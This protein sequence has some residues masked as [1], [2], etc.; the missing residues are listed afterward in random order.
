MPR[1]PEFIKA[2]EHHRAFFVRRCQSLSQQPSEALLL[3]WIHHD[4]MLEGRRFHTAEIAQALREQDD[5]LP[6]Y[7]HPLM[8]SIRRYRDAILFVWKK[9][10]N[11]PSEV[12]LDNLKR[13]HR[14]LTPLERDRPGQ[15]RVS[16]PVH[17]DYFQSICPHTVI[18]QQLRKIFES[19]AT[20][21]DEAWDPTHFAAKIHHRLMHA[22]PFRRNPGTTLRLFTN[23]LLLSRGY[24]PAIIPAHRRDAYYGALAHPE[25]DRV[26][27]VYSQA[28]S[29]LMER[30]S[31]PLSLVS[32]QATP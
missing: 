23:L 21:C 9:A 27:A 11:G 8:A 19:I 4:N 25:T 26:G 20:D 14:M 3:S 13:I 2:L 7:L 18:P 6:K 16:S 31:T 5:E 32:S 12:N 17:R 30:M 28:V 29:H 22:Y 24:P 15:Y 1:T 10:L